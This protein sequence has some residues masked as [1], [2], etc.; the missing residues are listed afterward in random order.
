PASRP[1]SFLPGTH[2]AATI[3]LAGQAPI[4][5]LAPVRFCLAALPGFTPP[6]PGQRE[7]SEKQRSAMKFGRNEIPR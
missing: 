3:Q 2:P 6:P 7:S 4:P 1:F 5:L